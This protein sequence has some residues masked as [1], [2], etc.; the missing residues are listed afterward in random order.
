MFIPQ[1]ILD[2][3]IDAIAGGP[4]APARPFRHRVLRDCSLVARS[5]TRRSQ[6]HLFSSVSLT[7]ENL[8][9]WCR[10][11]TRNPDSLTHFVRILEVKQNDEPG[12]PK[13]EQGRMEAALPYLN[14]PNLEE[15][16]LLQWDNLATFSLPQTFGHYSTPSLRSLTIIDSISNGDVL[17]ELAAIFHSVD[18]FVID[19]AYTTDER[20]TRTFSF[21]DHI[22]WRTLR[23]VSI[24]DSTMG[25]LNVIAG[26]RL[27]CQTLDISYE[28]LDDP[29][30]IMR[31][32]QACSQTLESMRLEQTYNGNPVPSLSLFPTNLRP[33]TEE[34]CPGI[35][36]S[37]LP[38]LEELTLCSED[39][40]EDL[41][42]PDTL[43]L[44]VLGSAI[45]PKL[46]KIIITHTDSTMLDDHT[47]DFDTGD[48]A[49]I[50]M[51]L[52]RLAEKT[53]SRLRVE[54]QLLTPFNRHS[55]G[56]IDS[57]LPAFKK[58]G[59][60]ATVLTRE[61]ERHYRSFR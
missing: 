44:D 11:N 26:L 7:P 47:Y 39:L 10:I 4:R 52:V 1:E 25:V 32:I 40:A 31:L 5:W 59:D 6:K 45:C 33:V 18:E 23:M 35:T 51:F 57:I 14:F 55:M 20:I 15:L 22:R 24:D 54:L 36:P 28:L 41:G 60:F 16:V 50:D 46:R 37:L 12:M 53:N 27:Q 29:G 58:V 30:P 43:K 38:E 9:S 49:K 3:I 42:Q 61:G 21:P 13:F 8:D 17:L 56:M 19:C 48:W 34:P 2:E